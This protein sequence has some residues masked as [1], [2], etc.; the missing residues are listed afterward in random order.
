MALAPPAPGSLAFARYI[1][2]VHRRDPFT[3]SGPVAVLIEASLPG[4]GKQSRLLAIRDTNESERSEYKVI[5][6][7]GDAAVT[8]EVITPYLAERKE[9]EDLPTSSVMMTPANYNFRYM[10][11][12]EIDGGSASVFR[13]VP[14]KKRRGLIRGELWIDSVTGVAVVQAGYFVKNSS[15]GIRRLEIVRGTKLQDGSPCSRITRVAVETRR[16]GRG[17][18]TITEFPAPE[19]GAAASAAE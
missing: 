6:S 1:A 9:I 17:Y 14:K 8:Q 4:P 15:A 18:L 10:G 7:E 5:D 13:V 2:S 11:E 16:A 12:A 3:E 19:M